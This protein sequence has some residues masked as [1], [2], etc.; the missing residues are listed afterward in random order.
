MK[1]FKYIF[2][3]LLV[4]VLFACNKDVT[5]RIIASFDL[6]KQAYE[7]D[8]LVYAANTSKAEGTSICACKWE[9]GE[10]QVCYTYD[11]A[12]SQLSPGEYTLK[13]TV[14]AEEGVAMGECEQTFVVNPEVIV[15]IPGETIVPPTDKQFFVTTTGAGT[16]D[17]L[18]WGNAFDADKFREMV[19]TGS[20]NSEID[21]STFYCGAGEYEISVSSLSEPTLSN[22][23][24]YFIGGYE[25]TGSA[26]SF[27]ED[28]PTIFK[29]SGACH[30][31]KVADAA[32]TIL[33][34]LKFVSTGF[35]GSEAPIVIDGDGAEATI[36]NS[37]LSSMS[38]EAGACVLLSRGSLMLKS[39]VFNSNNGASAI[40]S[41]GEGATELSVDKC[42]FS[43]NKLGAEDGAIV[44]VA[45]GKFSLGASTFSSN[46]AS[47][48]NLAGLSSE[49]HIDGTRFA[50]NSGGAVRLSN[51]S[52]QN[53]IFST[54]EFANNSSSQGGAVSAES[55]SSLEFN[56]CTFSSNSAI[57]G[58]AV[59]LE[60]VAKA[61]FVDGLFE[62]NNATG[63]D[64]ANGGGA[65]CTKGA[66]G[67]SI[68]NVKF[69]SNNSTKHGGALSLKAETTFNIINSEFGSASDGNVASDYGGVARVSGTGNSK[70]DNC[71]IIGNKGK[72]GGALSFDGNFKGT[73]EISKCEFTG[74][75][76]PDNAGDGGAIGVDNGALTVKD[77]S[78][79]GN[80]AK[81]GGAM[82][83]S[84]G[85]Q[86]QIT[87]CTFGDSKN[88]EASANGGSIKAFNAAV[89][90]I[91]R[92]TFK[93]N[94]WRGGALDLNNSAK[95]DI[96]DSKFY[97]CQA[98]TGGVIY[99]QKGPSLYCNRVIFE[100]NHSNGTGGVANDGGAVMYFQNTN[101]SL[102]AYF[103]ACSL[104]DNHWAN[105]TGSLIPMLRMNY[106]VAF[107]NCFMNNNY[108]VSTTPGNASG[109][110]TW[111][112]VV[113]ER[114]EV[115]SFVVS[116]SSL[117]GDLK[118]NDTPED[119]AGG[120]AAGILRFNTDVAQTKLK[121]GIVNS[122]ITTISPDMVHTFGVSC[123]D[124]TPNVQADFT[125]FKYNKATVEQ[126]NVDSTNYTDASLRG[127]SNYFTGLRWDSSNRAWLWNGAGTA[128]T[129][130]ASVSNVNSEINKVDPDFYS[131]LDSIGALSIDGLGNQRNARATWPGAY[132]GSNVQ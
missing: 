128:F 122:I 48:I 57:T 62:A 120:K 59:Y 26:S 10:G 56:D 131:W 4:P 43:D 73:C 109:Q 33:E 91:A 70:F 39:T 20:H 74:N 132:D 38:N 35:S 110:H 2:L 60:D 77:C 25:A 1:R 45:G 80:K 37:E 119:G 23:T 69:K 113:F 16:K 68:D 108:S 30:L 84:S 12:P 72:W 75:I 21:N 42:V 102:K 105:T 18:S 22:V 114:P 71:K 117:I 11:F 31:L 29:S 118:R 88:N 90:Q 127:N 6:T 101:T 50:F 9:W 100:G 49:A 104:T 111:F 126:L 96:S 55:T 32:T 36:N 27:P 17:G 63:S 40:V 47:A 99:A 130:L 92:C 82:S 67:L 41:V 61:S 53:I 46:M 76:S 123:Y 79:N 51:I 24:V 54:C 116:N 125:S 78:F 95:V 83:L 3:A 93:S 86:V 107:N 85:E 58:G 129:S 64:S 7:F 66:N 81:N 121:V 52:A 13:L 19:F 115:A 106:K 124:D 44:N 15:P 28:N 8:E 14:Y 87:D 112:N 103:N 5:P 89:I 34:S 97:S 98:N 94:A 65:I